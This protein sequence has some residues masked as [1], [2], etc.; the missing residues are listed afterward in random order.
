[1]RSPHIGTLAGVNVYSKPGA[2]GC[3]P[4]AS[5]QPPPSF[6]EQNIWMRSV[7]GQVGY[8]PL[9][10]E[11]VPTELD[12]PP[13]QTTCQVDMVVP[14]AAAATNVGAARQSAT[15]VGAARQSAPMSD[16]KKQRGS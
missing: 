1:M 9:F 5:V 10:C 4:F 6:I 2:A 11:F 12:C 3:F 16:L 13:V 8:V 14:A 7:V 15:N